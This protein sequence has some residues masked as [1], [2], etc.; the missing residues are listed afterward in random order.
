MSVPAALALACPPRQKWA[1]GNGGGEAVSD[2]FDG[3]EWRTRALEYQADL[4]AG[5]WHR[6]DVAG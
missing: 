6:G 4:Q 1:P 2:E 3:G 5:S